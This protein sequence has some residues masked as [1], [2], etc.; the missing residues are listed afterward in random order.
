[1]SGIK[2]LILQHIDLS[3]NK[4][5]FAKTKALLADTFYYKTTFTDEILDSSRY[6]EFIGTLREAIPDLSVEVEL[7]MSEKNN[8]M[9]Q[10]SF[11]G[12]VLHPFYGIPASNKIITFPA[13]SIWDVVDNKIK[14]V[15]TLIDITGV[16][17]QLGTPVIPEKPLKLRK[18]KNKN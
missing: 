16:S 17:R 2:Q 10:T 6:I 9:T 4:G 3:W 1:M 8:V 13:I 5:N 18:T 12:E 14:S 15:D 7:I 11:I